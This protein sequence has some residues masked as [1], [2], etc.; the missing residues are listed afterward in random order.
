MIECP[1]EPVA[2]KK[3]GGKPEPSPPSCGSLSVLVNIV[4]GLS[5]THPALLPGTANDLT[6]AGYL[7][8]PISI[9]VE[10]SKSGLLFNMPSAANRLQH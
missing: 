8:I 4:D 10:M 7:V 6:G 1:K 2:I 3:R 9:I 5:S